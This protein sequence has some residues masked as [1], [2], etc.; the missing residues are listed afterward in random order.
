VEGVSIDL[1]TANTVVCHTEQ[2]II[3]D[4]PSVM[5]FRQNGGPR[6]KVLA[7]GK[8]AQ[9]LI[10]RA[11]EGVEIIRPLED[12]VITDLETTRRYLREVLVRIAPGWWERRRLS[13]VFGVPAGATALERRALLEAAEEA[14]IGRAQL[15]LEPV[16]GAVGCG[17]N[18]L[19]ARTHLVVDIGA[20]TSEVAAFGSGGLL[21][22]RSSPLA[23]TE[24]TLA[25]YQHLRHEHQ[26]VVGELTAEQLKLQVGTEDRSQPLSVEGQDA[27]TGK[28]RVVDVRIEEL[29]GAMAPVV[30]DIVHTL[31]ACL[32]DV[33]AQSA[34]DVMSEGLIAVGGGSLLA[35]FP[36]TLEE[37]FGFEPLMADRPLTCV[38]E[39]GARC[40]A[41]PELLAA[42]TMPH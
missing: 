14:G 32:E 41:N 24:M 30:D 4:E 3:F 1:G 37:A 35:G 22:Y 10:G 15:V 29:A 19:K 27:S 26:L 23:G 36:K 25:I 12:G 11:P 7:I 2:G 33:P 5:A 40:L 8:A 31:A 17:V 9:S 16:A 13:V 28:P 39:G 42:C 38:A 20:G 34:N 18:P 21:A 6:P